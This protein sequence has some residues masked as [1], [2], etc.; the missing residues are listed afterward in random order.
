MLTLEL[1]Q[2]K[3]NGFTLIELLVVIAIIGVLASVVL[4]A[5][6]QARIK[7]QNTRWAADVYQITKAYEL[8][9]SD[10]GRYPFANGPIPV[11]ALAPYARTIATLLTYGPAS[12]FALSLAPTDPQWVGISDDRSGCVRVHNGYYIAVGS[13]GANIDTSND[14]GIEPAYYERYGGDLKFFR[15]TPGT[16]T[17]ASVCPDY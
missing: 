6:S 3:N 13:Y 14:G 2:T 1:K 5:T 7:A 11:A 9:Y 17:S 12:Y 16:Y 8:Y 15:S 4:F 10:F